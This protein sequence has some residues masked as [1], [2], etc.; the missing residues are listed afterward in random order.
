[1]RVKNIMPDQLPPGI[2]TL[3]F[4]CVQYPMLIFNTK[5]PSINKNML[6]KGICCMGW[7]LRTGL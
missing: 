2:I 1:M 3:K 7:H 5:H 4:N 6:R